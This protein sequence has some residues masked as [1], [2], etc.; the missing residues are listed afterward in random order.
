M[1]DVGDSARSAIAPEAEASTPRPGLFLR[2]EDWFFAGWIVLAAPALAQ[3]GGSGGPFDAGHPIDGLLRLTRFCGAILCLTTRSKAAPG[4]SGA[5]DAADADK[6]AGTVAGLNS[7][8][9]GPLVGG[10]MLVGGSALP[11]ST[12]TRPR[13][14]LQ[15]SGSS[16]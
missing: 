12:S 13:P 10:L 16:W 8:S 4:G 5:A 7:A 3:A 15:R 2:V 11:S 9:I 14:S 1:A 6:E